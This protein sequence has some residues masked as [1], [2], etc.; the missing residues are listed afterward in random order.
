MNF[1]TRIFRYRRLRR[2]ASRLRVRFDASRS[3]VR[4]IDMDACEYGRSLAQITG[5]EITSFAEFEK[6]E[7]RGQELLRRL[8]DE[9]DRMDFQKN[10]LV[11]PRMDMVTAYVMVD[12]LLNYFR[13]CRNFGLPLDAAASD[14]QW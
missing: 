13:A 5:E 6:I 3:H 1:T 8:S 10:Q 14:L 9:L 2:V 7:D 11:K 12:S 4:I